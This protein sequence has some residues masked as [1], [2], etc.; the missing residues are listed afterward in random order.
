MEN[1]TGQTNPL[2]AYFRKPGIWIKLPSRGKFYEQKPADLND[3]GEIAI[4]PLTAK[5][6]LMLKNADA[7]LNGSAITQV[8]KSCAPS[9]VDPENMPAIDLDAVLVAIKRCTYGESMTIT[10]TH[11]C[12]NAEPNEINID[13]NTIIA[14]IQV[15]EDNLPPVEFENGIKVFVE[16]VTVKNILALNWVQYEQI[17]TMQMAE[18]QNI[19]ERDKL[20]ML[21]TSYSALTGESI[22]V[23]S[24]CIDT[25]LLPDG[26]A[27]VDN[28]LIL[29]W[30]NDLSKPEYAKLEQA[31]MNTN[32][33]GINKEFKV[34]CPQCDKDYTSQIDLNPTTFF[35]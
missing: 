12:E 24:D 6:E 35:G 3:M 25:V 23:V 19:S 27:V 10:T 32:I 30:I 33:K 9:I 15:V 7:L 13:L 22:R 18:Q 21:Q 1:T 26:T 8:I 2:K 16:A 20:N 28:K 17:R 31:V 5:D 29:E 14:S 34:H 11:D 4:Y